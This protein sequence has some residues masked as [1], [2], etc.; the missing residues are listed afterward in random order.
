MYRVVGWSIRAVDRFLTRWTNTTQV[1]GDSTAWPGPGVG[2]L[3]HSGGWVTPRMPSLERV[4][5]NFV[6]FFLILSRPSMSVFRINGP[7]WTFTIRSVFSFNPASPPPLGEGLGA[8]IFA[9][10][11]RL[12][13]AKL[14][15]P[16]A[17][18]LLPAPPGSAIRFTACPN[19]RAT[20]PC[21]SKPAW[22]IGSKK[23]EKLEPAWN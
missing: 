8:L 12:P 4:Y 6:G 22:A 10:P 16:S 5:E 2:K 21:P 23:K 13:C 17:I 20:C 11:L 9:C 7:F 19:P 1:G 14:F 15:W 18:R 3:I